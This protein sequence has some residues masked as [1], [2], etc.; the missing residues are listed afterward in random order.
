[1]PHIIH[2]L[3]KWSLQTTSGLPPSFLTLNLTF[4]LCVLLLYINGVTYSL[5]TSPNDNLEKLFMPTSVFLR[6]FVRNLVPAS[7]RPHFIGFSPSALERKQAVPIVEH[8]SLQL[9]LVNKLMQARDQF[10]TIGPNQLC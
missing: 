10:V 1:M 7:P 9:N 4:M 2:T 6:G 8:D 5:K 3:H